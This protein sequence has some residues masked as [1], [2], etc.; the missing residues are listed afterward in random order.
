LIVSLVCLP[1]AGAGAAFFRGWREFCPEKVAVRPLQ[2]PGREHRIREAPFR[3]VPAAADALATETARDIASGPIAVFGHSLGAVLGYELTR[4]LLA[5]GR[6]VTHL[7]VSGAPGPTIPRMERAATLEDDRFLERVEQL[8]G[9]H[10]PAFDVPELRAV[11]LPT[12]RADVEM[13]ENYLPTDLATID[14]PIVA[15]RGAND[16]LVPPEHVAQWSLVAAR[17]FRQVE[18]PG[19]HMYLLED[20]RRVVDLVTGICLENS[21]RDPARHGLGP[22]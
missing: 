11:L 13:H 15:L 10:H 2:L 7:F 6:D 1:F 22:A 19:G 8:A 21:R 3:H 16:K 18:L 5:L 14:V 4:R 20:A 9:Y 12:L 17:G